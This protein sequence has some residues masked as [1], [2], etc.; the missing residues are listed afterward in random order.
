M[1]VPVSFLDQGLQIP[2]FRQNPMILA[3][4]GCGSLAVGS[5]YKFRMA[6]AIMIQVTTL[7]PWSRVILEKLVVAQLFT[8]FPTFNGTRIII[9]VFTR[10]RHWSSQLNPFHTFPHYFLKVKL[11]LCLT[12]YHA[13]KA[14]WESRRIAPRILNF[15]IRWRWVV[16]FTSRPLY[17]RGKS[18]VTHW[19]G[20]WTRWRK[21]KIPAPAGNR[22]PVIQP[23]T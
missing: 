13:T 6:H 12:K 2:C 5:R 23:V 20:G 21:T 11:F 4:A 9:I 8:K 10:A 19:I 7:T 16:S 3:A 17:P 15:G 22:T 14:Y 1:I 18:P